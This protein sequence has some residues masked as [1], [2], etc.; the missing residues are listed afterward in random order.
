MI[1]KFSMYRTI[2]LLLGFILVF[3]AYA[4]DSDQYPKKNKVE[5]IPAPPPLLP[6]FPCPKIPP[7]V[8]VVDHCY[9]DLE[10]R[11]LQTEGQHNRGENFYYLAHEF[12]SRNSYEVID[13]FQYL[14]GVLVRSSAGV[15]DVAL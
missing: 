6:K 3:T 14:T 10:N 15:G 1:Q 7:G 4:E 13:R 8:E 2:T 12:F 9:E 11:Y 5:R